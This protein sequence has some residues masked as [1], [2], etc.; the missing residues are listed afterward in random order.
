MKQ[1]QTCIEIILP[2]LLLTGLGYFLRR[3]RIMT[4]SLVEGIQKLIFKVLLPVISFRLAWTADLRLLQGQWKLLLW[5][6]GFL[7][8]YAA[9][10]ILVLRRSKLDA[11][12]KAEAAMGMV[13]NNIV[14]FGL[15]ITSTYY[16]V[17][18]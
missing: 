13:V 16:Q 10:V 15:P 14:M 8:V 18:A 12:T 7:L 17:Q 4:Q 9:V 6:C 1:V 5:G 2:F 3:L 11:W